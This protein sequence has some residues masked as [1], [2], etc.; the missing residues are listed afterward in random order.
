MMFYQWLRKAAAIVPCFFLF[1]CTGSLF[2]HIT[3]QNTPTI[4]FEDDLAGNRLQQAIQRSLNY[5]NKQPQDAQFSLNGQQIPVKRII[6]SLNLLEKILRHDLSPREFQQEISRQFTLYQA[7]GLD[8][9][10]TQGQ[11]LV[12]GYFQPVLDGSLIKKPPYMYP[13]Y[14]PPPY[15]IVR[16]AKESGE[17]SI[18]RY[19]GE[20]FTDYWSRKDIDSRGKAAGSEL[21]WLKDPLDVFFLHVQGSGLI[22]LTD[23]SVRGIHYATGNGRPYQ[24]IGR[25][26]VKTG[27]ISLHNASMETIRSYVTNHP[28]EQEKILFTNPSYIFFNWSRSHGAVGNLGQELTAGRSIAVDQ[29]LFPAGAPCFLLTKEPVIAHNTLSSWRSVHR[30]VLV[31]DSGSAIKGTGRVDLFQGTGKQ[32]GLAAGAMKEN[33]TLFFLLARE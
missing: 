7:A 33:G 15:L 18:V 1:A 26:M 16:S 25:F 13:L 3:G 28:R 21:V 19:D 31:Q 24:S 11:M 17:K 4:T 20:H 8:K 23:G 10:T 27:K 14:E 9:Q 6:R 30:F 2:S 22:R 5:L 12:T 29:T 32:A